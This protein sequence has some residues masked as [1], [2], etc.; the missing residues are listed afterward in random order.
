MSE[1]QE[2]IDENLSLKQQIESFKNIVDIL[3][4]DNVDLKRKVES[5]AKEN[6]AFRKTVG[7][8]LASAKELN[9]VNQEKKNL[10]EIVEKKEREIA[11]LK[12]LE[13]TEKPSLKKDAELLLKKDVELQTVKK[14]LEECRQRENSLSLSLETLKEK[15]K[16]TMPP[17][18][19]IKRELARRLEALL[20]ENAVLREKRIVIQTLFLSRL[21]RSMQDTSFTSCLA[22]LQRLMLM[23]E[24]KQNPM[25]F[26]AEMFFPFP[27]PRSPKYVF[28]GNEFIKAAT[29]G[30]DLYRVPL[31]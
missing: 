3:E 6:E 24:A 19:N 14:A 12:D 22:I 28:F 7:E 25:L 26:E 21:S 27:A 16:E 30:Q 4:K 17:Q 9:G 10:E 11:R 13:K 5:S 8:L 31:Q 29:L 1:K 23:S 18:D 20:T 15:E 2:L